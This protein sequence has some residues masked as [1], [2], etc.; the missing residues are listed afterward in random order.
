[1]DIWIQSKTKQTC[2]LRPSRRRLRI[3]EKTRAASLSKATQC[4]Q[5]TKLLPLYP[6]FQGVSVCRDVN[7]AVS[8]FR[9]CI[10]QR[11]IWRP[12]N[13]RTPLEGSSRCSPQMLLLFPLF[14]GCTAAILCG[15]TYSKIL[16]TPEKEERMRENGTSRDVDRHFHGPGWQKLWRKE[17]NI[18]SRNQEVL[19]RLDRP[20]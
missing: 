1:M 20:I 6:Q 15:R 19:Q 7:D 11:S 12:I 8:Q 16:C 10:L 3:R 13:I 2:A 9:V 14:G 17:K 4:N 5:L 18:W